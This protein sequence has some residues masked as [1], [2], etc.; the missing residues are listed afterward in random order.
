MSILYFTEKSGYLK[1]K[2]S[3]IKLLSIF[4]ASVSLNRKLEVTI[5]KKVATH[6][7]ISNL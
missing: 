7:I 2:I 1:K 4:L 5:G 3:K 6:I